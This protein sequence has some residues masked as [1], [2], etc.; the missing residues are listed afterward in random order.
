MSLEGQICESKLFR[1]RKICARSNR[2]AGDGWSV[3]CLIDLISRREV[4][5]SNTV[6]MKSGRRDKMIYLRENNSEEG[7]QHREDF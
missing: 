6:Q 2:V 7:I 4:V 3:S 1:V 5:E